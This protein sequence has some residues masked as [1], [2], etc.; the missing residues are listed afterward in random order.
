MR[1]IPSKATFSWNASRDVDGLLAGHRVEHEQHVRRLHGGAIRSSS[2]ISVGVDLVAAGGVDDH[3]VA[4]VLGPLDALLAQPTGSLRSPLI[5]RNLDLLA[6][7]LEL[8][9][10]GGALQVGGDERR[11]L[12]SLRSISASFAAAVVLPE[13]WRPASRI[14]VGRA[15]RRRAASRCRP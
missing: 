11:V 3:D 12:P 7:L 8:V 6:E 13:P 1:T 9:D 10:R 4:P 2:S 15:A 14:T 5:D